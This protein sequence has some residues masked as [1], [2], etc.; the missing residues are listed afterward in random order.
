[1]HEKLLENLAA[2]PSEYRSAPFWAWNST[3][4]EEE[5]IRQIH[6]LHEMGAG[7]FFMHARV[8]L[9]TA[10]LGDE[11]F[12]CVR[13]CI[14]EAEKLGMT[15]H[16]YDEDRWPSGS[17]GGKVTQH[18]K[19]RIQALAMSSSL[20]PDDP[21][22]E[23][24]R[25]FAVEYSAG[26]PAVWRPC[27]MNDPGDKLH[28]YCCTAKPESWYN[29]GTY[30]NTLDPEAVAEFIRIAYEPYAEKFQ[31]KFGNSAGSIFTDEPNYRAALFSENAKTVRKSE[32]RVEPPKIL[33]WTAELPEKFQEKYGYDILSSLPELFYE[34]NG[35]EFSGL[36][37]NYFNL[38]TG[39]FVEA[40]M[41][42]IGSWCEKHH[43]PLTGHMHWEDTLTYQRHQV[44]SAMRSYEY[45]QQPGIDQLTE[46]LQ[47]FDTAK[48]CVSVAHQLGKKRRLT[49]CYGCTG[50]DFPFAG[51]KALGEWQYALG[52]NFRCP[53][54]AWYSAAGD[55]K[56]DYPASI[57]FQSPWYQKYPV[58]EEHFARLGAALDAGQ[59]VRN[60]LVIHPIES[61]WGY[62]SDIRLTPAEAWAENQSLIDVRNT[63]LAGNLDFDYGDEE[64]MSRHASVAGELLQIGSAG[65]LAVV[66]PP[67]RTIRR[68]TLT[69]LEKFARN[70]GSVICTGALPEY[71]DA[72]R[73]T[74]AQNI[75]K[76]FIHVPLTELSAKLADFREVSI[77]AGGVEV[78]PV[79]PLLRRGE[80]FQSLFV[81][82][83]GHELGK[84][85]Q[86]HEPGVLEREAEFPEVQISLRSSGRGEIVELD[87]DSG[88]FYAVES[89]Y[90]D[91]RRCF[92]T[93]FSQLG[94]RF[95]IESAEQ[96]PLASRP[97][98]PR[99]ELFMTLP[100]EWAYHCAGANTLV[101]DEAEFAIDH[102][103]WQE[104]EFF[105]FIDNAIRDHLAIPR[106]G[107]AMAQPYTR[108]EKQS[109]KTANLSLRYSFTVRDIPH[110]LQLAT[111]TPELFNFE[112]NG[113][114]ISFEDC[115]FWVDPAIRRSVLPVELLRAGENILT[116]NTVYSGEH[117]GI[118]SCFLLGDFGISQ[119]DCLIRKPEKLLT[120]DYGAQGLKYY[121]DNLTYINHF[122]LDEV[123]EMPLFISF[124]K[125]RGALLG[126]SVNGGGEQLLP[127][128][129]YTLEI[130]PYLQCGKNTVSIT[131]YGHRRNAFGPFY[132][133][134]ATPFWNGPLQFKTR[135]QNAKQLVPAGLLESVKI[136]Y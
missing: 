111:E 20:L 107:G 37:C 100:D 77:S 40:Y 122:E 24:L 9:N 68:S 92:T 56:R 78:D 17:A 85:H 61:T 104:K 10:F 11:W 127:W 99:G 119:R 63:L 65:Y 43:L 106:R 81:C 14:S 93:S 13:K 115:G 123:P 1:M 121:A 2:L 101:L 96:W 38:L 84:F 48:Q 112:L 89:V 50:W 133:N 79:L 117:P 58:V 82:N 88:K 109:G 64:L 36:R 54:L 41:K 105:I 46:H 113:K 28:F 134:E 16:F 27:G 131:V 23:Y 8:G 125:W 15:A 5:L 31:D 59:E 32:S 80:G 108:M 34:K 126:V 25:S 70:G 66:I 98:I 94:S 62:K 21:D 57:F 118:E 26:V 95:F 97:P 7:G 74:D 51:Y 86:E 128:P 39:L 132:M 4:K 116:V 124:G 12:D 45:M 22:T 129:P 120:G 67:L 35:E 30:V 136:I 73:D 33:P 18:K 135:Q 49:E 42:Q 75:F 102:G 87:L 53:H 103:K 47:I 69:L 19:Y 3:L 29:H 55:A 90:R 130:T 83:V 110:D 52:I 44:G 71:V 72:V 6:I 114:K 91:G 76:L 60:I